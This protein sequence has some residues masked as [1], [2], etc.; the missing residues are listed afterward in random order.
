MN[1]FTIVVLLT[2][3]SLTSFGQETYPGSIMIA[4]GGTE[5]YNDWS[6]T[7]YGWVVEHAGNKRIAVITYETS[8]SN[9][10]P[11]YFE[12]LGAEEAENFSV[13]SRDEADAE[14]LYE[15]LK[16]YEGIF[17]KGGDQ[18]KYYEYYKNTRLQDAVKEIYE[19]GGVLS[20]TS[21]GLAILS[22]VIFSA[23]NGTVYSHE[24][25]GDPNNQYMTLRDDFLSVFPGF[26]FDSHFAERGR[27]GRLIGFLG[28]WKLNQDDEITG[29]GVD[30]KTAFCI[31]KDGVGR[32]FGTGAVSIYRI[33]ENNDFRLNDGHLLA[34]N[35][36]VTQLLH[37]DAI[38][39]EDFTPAGLPDD[40]SPEI[41]HEDY[42]GTLWFSSEEGANNNPPLI[43]KLIAEGDT[44][45]PIIIVS[46]DMS[47][48]ATYENRFADEGMNNTTPLDPGTVSGDSQEWTERVQN[49]TK[50]LFASNSGAELVDFVN[51]TAVGSA[52]LE[53]M[54]Q[55][56]AAF[57]GKDA[58]FAGKAY[59]SNY[60]QMYASYDGLLEFEEGL[61]LLQST[62]IQPETFSSSD[63]WENTMTAVPYLMN[64]YRLKYGVWLSEGNLMKYGVE[65]N[66]TFITA[67]RNF[68]AILL[69][70]EGTQGG[71]GEV[72][73]VSSGDPRNVSGFGE[74]KLR[75]IDETTRQTV[76]MLNQMSE[77]EGKERIKVWPNPAKEM[78][79]IES[80][81]ENTLLRIST[82]SGKLLRE[83]KNPPATLQINS[84]SSGIYFLTIQSGANQWNKKIIIH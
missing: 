66:E 51:N 21:A 29:I 43:R 59:C 53:Q 12:W 60:Q 5:N 28:N 26:I 56:Y 65:D 83:F 44:E 81:P 20:G 52:L 78:F 35:L 36:W 54:K 57:A 33:G 42:P 71:L 34:D 49:H 22:G 75:L 77:N 45:A 72:S 79:N 61:G 46:S 24:A 55:S 64:L 16:T 38:Q 13:S 68:P 48:A 4:G 11:D 9:W 30:D 7:P 18:S 14:S 62:T 84:L 74:M 27:F 3:I 32:A 2:L 67:E 50:F 73:A 31:G 82:A 25:L 80:I 40:I 23:E 58:R 10:M 76:G 17:F 70:N 41:V 69:I 15:A 39:M 8:P 63:Y 19:E 37:N 1:K 47:V 6:D